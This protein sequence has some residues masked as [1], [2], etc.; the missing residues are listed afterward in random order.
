MLLQYTVIVYP[1]L[2]VLQLLLF[3]EG[4]FYIKIVLL[5][6]PTER[7]LCLS[8]S[9]M[10][11]KNKKKRV[12]IASQTKYASRSIQEI[13]SNKYELLE[14]KLIA[15]INQHMSRSFLPNNAIYYTINKS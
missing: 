10:L 1:A 5:F 15:A 7:L 4:S 11:T 6:G 9:T 13:I 14:S 2:L 12:A 8:T 3:L